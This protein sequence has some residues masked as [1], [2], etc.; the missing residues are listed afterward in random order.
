M[1]TYKSLYPDHI[2]TINYDDLVSK[3]ESEIRQ[4]INWLK[5]EWSENYLYPHLNSRKV[6]TTSKVQ[7]RAPINKKSLSSWKNYKDLLRPVI[8]YFE[9]Q[10]L[11][12]S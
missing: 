5:F 6:S 4:L 9:K 12:I 1:Q 10:D 2:F 8:E 3:P 11:Y 7:V